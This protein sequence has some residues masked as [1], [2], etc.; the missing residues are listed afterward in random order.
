M[1]F[2]E[3][4]PMKNSLSHILELPVRVSATAVFWLACSVPAWAQPAAPVAP[5]A[6]VS[7]V[8]TVN[9]ELQEA[10]RGELLLR[11]F[12]GRGA[13]DSPQLRAAVRETLINQAVMSQEAIKQELNK[14]PLVKA[15]LALAEQNALAQMWQQKTI[16]DAQVSDA[17][18]QAEYDRQVKA[19]GSQEFRVRHVLLADETKAKQ[20]LAKLKD[21]AKFETMAG[22]SSMDKV[23][24]AQG[25]LSDWMPEG[26]L[27][28]EVFAAIKGLK[29][30]QLVT[31]PVKTASGWQVLRLEEK[32]PAQALSLDAAKPQIRLALAQ[33]QVQVRLNALKE[34]AKI[35]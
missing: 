10:E 9:G 27:M 17:D 1:H 4:Y 16:Q 32:R 34:A 21:G 15:R 20:I 24:A 31:Q 7:L 18:I 6:P 33:R 14:L 2:L 3:T 13:A 29:N 19:M 30:G 22:E 35:N 28:P 25:G 11:E 5:V 8:V 26:R 12:M 23:T